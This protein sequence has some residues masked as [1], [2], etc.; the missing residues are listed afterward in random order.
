MIQDFNQRAMRIL[1][2]FFLSFTA[3]TLYVSIF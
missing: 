3:L 1:V 2:P